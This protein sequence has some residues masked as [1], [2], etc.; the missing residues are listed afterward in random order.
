MGE[1]DRRDPPPPELADV[2]RRLEEIQRRKRPNVRWRVSRHT[3]ELAM[4]ALE[5]DVRPVKRSSK[6]RRRKRAKRLL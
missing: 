4:R 6:C 5:S 1:D 2:Q 3:A